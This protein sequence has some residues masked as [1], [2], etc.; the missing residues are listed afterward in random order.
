[1]NF[2]EYTELFKKKAEEKGLTFEYIDN[3]LKYAEPL[4]K[5]SI[6]IIYDQKH[7]SLLL[8]IDLI[9]L[10]GVS[11]S[12]KCYYRKFEIKKRNG[13]K[14]IIHEPL[15]L[16]KEIQT[17]I[18]KEILDKLIPSIYTK[19]FKKNSS[20]KDNAKFHR[21]QKKVICL[22]IK[23]YFE[24]IKYNKVYLFFSDLGYASDVAMML[25]KICT[26]K[27]RLPQGAPTS[28]ALSNLLTISLDNKLFKLANQYNPPLRYSRYADDITFSGRVD[29]TDLIKKVN[30]I[31]YTENFRL[32]FEKTRVLASNKC[33]IVTG[34]VVNK[35]LQVNKKKRKEIRQIMYYIRK[36]GLESHLNKIKW[37][38]S[39]ES[40]IRYLL[41]N[42]NFILFINPKDYNMVEYKKSLINLLEDKQKVEE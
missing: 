30:S 14:R 20:I 24:S 33:Q 3:C 40:Y 17:W 8:G 28:P 36:R 29:S 1:M 22:D 37:L 4:A 27:N 25:S 10:Y 35:K 13:K 18:L 7:L 2:H 16:L 34:I 31:V 15:P 19:A 9:Y 39:K 6:P 21:N 26:Y 38:N 23:D 5:K 11:N 12:S 42:I 32:N 41:G